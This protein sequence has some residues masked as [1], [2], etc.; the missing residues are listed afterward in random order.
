MGPTASGKSALGI[1]LAQKLGGVILNA[2]AMQCYA[3]LRIITA[4]PGEE[5]EAQVPH[6][7]YGIW[8]A[9]THGNTALWQ[10]AAI[11]E[12]RDVHAQGR[13]PILLG[14][15]G[16][17]IKSLMEGL[18]PIPQISE[19]V[20]HDVRQM[21]EDDPQAAYEKL[22][23]EDRL[24]AGRLD[25]ND[26]QRVIRALE[27]LEETGIGLE[28]WQAYE[29]TPPFGED[30]YLPYYVDMPREL[31]YERIDKRFEQMIEAGVLEEIKAL[32]DKT[33]SPSYP[34]MRAH[35]VPELMAHLKGKMS[36]EEAVAKAQ[37]NTRNYAKRQMTWLRNQ[38]PEAAPIP[39]DL[40]EDEGK[41]DAFV[42]DLAKRLDPSARAA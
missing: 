10:E 24:T 18:A 15:T 8:E 33:L 40:L 11:P 30:Q 39:Y 42:A 36:L 38:L 7:L 12:I 21:W 41:A 29:T 5:E 16:M 1:C 14:G 4:R 27:V 2:D 35:G 6:R 19:E 28:E 31:V 20:R 34:I 17:Y 22:L 23:K 25:A 37:Q 32:M 26:K 9:K 3:D 13:L